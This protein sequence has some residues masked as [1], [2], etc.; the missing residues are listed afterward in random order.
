MI[1]FFDALLIIDGLKLSVI[2]RSSSDRNLRKSSLQM[3]KFWLFIRVKFF[4]LQ[5]D[6]ILGQNPKSMSYIV[7]YGQKYPIHVH[8]RGA[9]LTSIHVLQSTIGCVE[10]FENWYRRPEANPNIIYG[11][12][13]GG[14]NENDEF[15]DDRS[16]YEQTEPTISGTAPLFGLFSKLESVY[17]N[18]GTIT[19]FQFFGSI[20]RTEP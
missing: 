11:A 4:C 8:H 19:N 1:L 20:I 18:S 7:G 5:A 17:G 15:I 12:L 9:S 16:N 6:Y 14:P 13:V 3:I 10:G 2:D